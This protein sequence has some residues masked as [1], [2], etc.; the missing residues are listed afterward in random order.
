MVR[1]P[2]LERPVALPVGFA[3][4]RKGTDSASRLALGRRLVEALVAPVA[5]RTVHELADSAYAGRAL[6]DLPDHISWTTRLRVNAAL[7]A[8]APPRTGKQARPRSRASG[9]PPQRPW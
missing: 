9:W 1:L 7:S 4:V 6:D 8:L 5:G 3:L 2:F